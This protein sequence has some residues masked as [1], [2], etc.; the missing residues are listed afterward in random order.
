M[1][2]P[3]SDHESAFYRRLLDLGRHGELAPLLDQALA[4]IV[5]FTGAKIAYLE[6]HQGQDSFWR[7]R[8]GTNDEIARIRDLVSRGIIQATLAGSE[9]VETPS[10]RT[11][12]RFAQH[13]SVQQHAIDAVLCAPVGAPPIGVV[14][15]QGRPDGESSRRSTGTGRRCS[16]PSSRWWPSDSAGPSR[17]E[18]LT[19]TQPR[20]GGGSAAP[21]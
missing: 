8:G 17:R 3:F 18:Q 10:A 1:T 11:D 20:S 15:L 4:L 7:A 9:T 5:D 14:Y 19:I 2:A 12:P 13:R 6:L 21:P 16:R